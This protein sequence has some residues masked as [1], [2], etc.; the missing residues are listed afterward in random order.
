MLLDDLAQCRMLRA[1]ATSAE[2]LLYLQ[3]CNLTTGREVRFV[4]NKR[5]PRLAI[6]DEQPP[7]TVRA[8]IDVFD[9]ESHSP[10]TF[11]LMPHVGIERRNE[12]PR[13]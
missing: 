1:G 2:K 7:I 12:N 8:T 10:L 5:L 11:V 13:S 6:A 3:I 4:S 9:Q